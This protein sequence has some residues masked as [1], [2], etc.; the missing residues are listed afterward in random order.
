MIW[1]AAD[2]V[3][4]PSSAWAGLGTAIPYALLLRTKRGI[5][6]FAR[7]FREGHGFSRAATALSLAALAAE[8]RVLK[9]P[10]SAGD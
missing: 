4:R 7:L 9:S 6:F 3:P 8:S 2:R 5:C 1:V 10:Q